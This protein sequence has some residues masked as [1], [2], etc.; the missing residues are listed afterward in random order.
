M[1][2]IVLKNI[3]VRWGGFSLIEILVALAIVSVLLA[4]AIPALVTSKKDSREAGTQGTLW[5]INVGLARAYKDKDPQFLEGGILSS[6]PVVSSEHP[7]AT[8]NALAYLIER[9][10]VR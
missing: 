7:N 8:E 9:G 4:F 6:S 2:M 5:T 3:T 1:G 10:Y